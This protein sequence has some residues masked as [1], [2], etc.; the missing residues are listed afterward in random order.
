VLIGGIAQKPGSRP[1]L[2]AFS[3]AQATS[4]P[5]TQPDKMSPDAYD[6]HAEAETALDEAR[7][8]SPGSEKTEALKMMPQHALSSFEPLVNFEHP[9]K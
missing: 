5:M 6:L 2:S 8:L 3:S 1:V 7:R 4:A 9:A